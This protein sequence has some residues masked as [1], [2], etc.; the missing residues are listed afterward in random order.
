M[1]G[2]EHAAAR[3]K[4]QRIFHKDAG[5]I[6]AAAYVDLDIYRLELASVFRRCW[7]FLAHETQIPKV[8]DFLATYMGEDPVVVVRQKDSGVK[9]FLNQCRHRGMRL[10]RSKGHRSCRSADPISMV[11]SYATLTGQGSLQ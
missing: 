3:E 8:G 11:Y 9:A 2:D 4:A 1:P 7:L 10:C 5:T 6:A